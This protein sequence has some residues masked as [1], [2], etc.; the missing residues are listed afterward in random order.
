VAEGSVSSAQTEKTEIGNGQVSVFVVKIN[1][2]KQIQRNNYSGNAREYQLFLPLDI[3]V[4]IETN[5][6][7]R[8]LIDESFCQGVFELLSLNM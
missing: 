8:L 6:S 3:E 7:V 1:M 2:T 4:K 5:E